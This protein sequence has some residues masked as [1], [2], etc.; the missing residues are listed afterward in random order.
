M[1]DAGNKKHSPQLSKVVG[2]FLL[3]GLGVGYVISGDYYGWNFG[4]TATGYWG[5]L[6]AIGMMAIMYASLV[7]VIAEMSAALMLLHGWH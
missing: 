2:P 7:G 5:F 3:W 1:V 6:I 4:L